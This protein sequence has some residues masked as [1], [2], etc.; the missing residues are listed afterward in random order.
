MVGDFVLSSNSKLDSEAGLE[1]GILEW[2]FRWKYFDAGISMSVSFVSSS[3]FALG[4]LTRESNGEQQ[5]TAGQLA[6]NNISPSPAGLGTLN[7]SRSNF[8]T[9]LGSTA[10]NLPP[11]SCRCLQG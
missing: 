9:F 6:I 7:V 3:L 2:G 11:T 5:F 10:Q 8:R 4:F 1:R